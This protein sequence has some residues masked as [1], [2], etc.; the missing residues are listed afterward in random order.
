MTEDNPTGFGAFSVDRRTVRR[1]ATGFGQGPGLLS[2]S[3]VPAASG[4]LAVPMGADAEGG[5]VGG[6]GDDHGRLEG[7]THD[8]TP[9]WGEDAVKLAGGGGGNGNSNGT[10]NGNGNGGN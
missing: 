7:E 4:G 6:L 10:S 1:S 8:G 9:V 2:A 5:G 3:T